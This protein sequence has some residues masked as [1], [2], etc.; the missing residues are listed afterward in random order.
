MQLGQYRGK[1]RYWQHIQNGTLKVSP[2]LMFK[3]SYLTEKRKQ[4]IKNSNKHT[5]VS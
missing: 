4:F 1:W 2:K 3:A 5:L